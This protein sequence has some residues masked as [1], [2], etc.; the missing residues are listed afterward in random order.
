MK[1]A[2][3]T[4]LAATILFV[5]GISEAA[6]RV[7]SLGTMIDDVALNAGSGLTVTIGPHSESSATVRMPPGKNPAG[8]T[9]L[10]LFP[11]YTH[12]NDGTLVLTVTVGHT[13]AAATAAPGWCTSISSGACTSDGAGV[14]NIAVTGD[15]YRPMRLGIKGYPVV[16]IVASHAGADGDDKITLTGYLVD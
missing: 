8:F 11:N 1:Q 14:I 7:Y 15:T 13:V 5:A 3:K 9:Y 10:V 2:I 6:P 16:K 12:N 4:L